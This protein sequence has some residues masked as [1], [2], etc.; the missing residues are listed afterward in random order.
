METNNP[1]KIKVTGA[2]LLTDE[3]RTFIDEKLYKLFKLIPESDTTALAEVEIESTAN[4]RVGD[5]YRAEITFT[6]AGGMARAE[7]RRETLHTAI[8]EAVGEARRE[9]RRAKNKRHDLA[10]RGAAQVKEFFRNFKNP[11]N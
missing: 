2:I 4:S 6:Y 8:D 7:A 9:L 10:R 3:L 1:V 11:F 5:S